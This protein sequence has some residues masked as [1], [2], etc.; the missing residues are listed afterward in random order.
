MLR[1]QYRLLGQLDASARD[2]CQRAIE[3]L[4]RGYE[5]EYSSLSMHMGGPMTEHECIEVIDIL[6]MHRELRWSYDDLA[7]KSEVDEGAITFRGFDGNNE[8]KELGY[9]RFLIEDENKFQE[10]AG[11]GGSLNSHM[12]TLDTYRRMLVV[13]RRAAGRHQSSSAGSENLLTADEMR[14]ITEARVHPS[15]RPS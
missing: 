15:N 6:Q 1:N 11:P 14:Q 7:D 3:M 13:W 9:A 8:P 4:D 5:L 10:L 12:P 2:E